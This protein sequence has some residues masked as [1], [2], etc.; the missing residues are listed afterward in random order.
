V[1][2]SEPVVPVQETVQMPESVPVVPVQAPVSAEKKDA[3][4]EMGAMRKFLSVV[5]CIVMTLALLAAGVIL[6][7]HQSVS[8]GSIEKMVS[9]IDASDIYLGSMRGN[10]SLIEYVCE[11]SDLDEKTIEKIL[12]KDFVKE[13]LASKLED[14]VKDIFYNTG[15][16]EI[17]AKE[18]ARLLEKNSDTIDRIAGESLGSMYDYT[19]YSL[20]V[21]GNLDELSV[22]A[23]REE[24]PLPF[25]LIRILCSYWLMAL[26]LV[27]AVAAGVGLFRLQNKKIRAFLYLGISFVI[28]GII[29]LVFALSV[30]N[31]MLSMNDFIELGTSFWR[32][33]ASPIR[34]AGLRD[35]GILA[36]AGVVCIVASKVGNKSAQKI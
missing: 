36:V 18:I 2:V 12:K 23:L 35:G 16:G 5:C 28:V 22:D 30:E 11:Q 8:K 34:S 25:S 7:V 3:K 27:I 29:N 9:E 21:K 6:L 33:L 14:Y 10:P 32:T 24:N 31:I 17:K 4:T 1:P 20:N 26:M 13:F 15:E 19:E